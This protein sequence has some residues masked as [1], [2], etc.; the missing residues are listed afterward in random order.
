M[1]TP[2][3]ESDCSGK[4]VS[5]IIDCRDRDYDECQLVTWWME[6]LTS[7]LH[8]AFNHYSSVTCWCYWSFIIN[9]FGFSLISTECQCNPIGTRSDAD[10]PVN[11]CVKDD[12]KMY[13]GL[14]SQSLYQDQVWAG[15]LCQYACEKWQQ[16]LQGFGKSRV[17]FRSRSDVDHPVNMTYVCERRHQNVPGF[18]KSESVSGPGLIRTILSI[19]VRKMTAKFTRIW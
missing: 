16:D 18:G 15:P 4:S 10:H 6:H 19:C 1:Q 12:S 7:D 11:M 5:Q 17:W 8:F 9:F 14:V 3:N 13:Q 2:E